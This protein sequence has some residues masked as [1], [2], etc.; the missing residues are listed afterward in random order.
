MILLADD[1][2]KG[3]TS[4][5]FCNTLPESKN[6]E[7]F[8]PHAD[9]HILCYCTNEGPDKGTEFCPGIASHV[10]GLLMGKHWGPGV[11]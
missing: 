10:N 11:T 4:V 7:T 9:S 2:T 8:A 1:V 5:V 6:S 3:L